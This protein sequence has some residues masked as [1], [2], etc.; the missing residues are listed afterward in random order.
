MSVRTFF[1][2]TKRVVPTNYKHVVP[3]MVRLDWLQRGSNYNE[4]ITHAVDS[5][6]ANG[7]A[8]V[9]EYAGASTVVG[10]QGSVSSPKWNAT[11]FA[12]VAPVRVVELMN[13]QSLGYCRDGQCGFRSPLILPLL[14]Q[15]L[16]P[17]ASLKLD[18]S[19]G[20][21]NTTVTN[22]S[23]VDAY[24]YRCLSCYA[25]QLDTTK[26]DGAAFGAALGARVIAPARHA[27]DLLFNWPYLTRMFTTISPAE[28][29]E[30]PEFAERDGLANVNPSGFAA[31]RITCS[32][33]SARRYEQR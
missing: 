21:A 14:H 25:N 15:Y 30:D 20:P 11:P 9:T 29:T 23:L 28:M 18:A 13:E 26:W 16:P 2:G 5:P 10:S 27:D 4:L 6:I 17:P 1:L 24:F 8:F 32:G 3:N 12:T 31:Q 7:H 33:A 22:P 19:Q